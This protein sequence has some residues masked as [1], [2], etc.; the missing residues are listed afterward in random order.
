M[1]GRR[2]RRGEAPPACVT[3]AVPASDLWLAGRKGMGQWR[4][5]WVWS[6]RYI[7]FSLP[8]SSKIPTT[9]SSPGSDSGDSLPTLS[10]QKCLSLYLSVCLWL[11]PLP[12]HLVLSVCLCLLHACHHTAIYLLLINT[13][14]LY[15]TCMPPFLSF[16][17]VCL[18]ASLIYTTMPACMTC[19]FP[20][21]LFVS[22]CI[23][24]FPIWLGQFCACA[25]LPAIKIRHGKFWN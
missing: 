14:T 5:S 16:L 10:L 20:L 19:N 11:F 18:F 22:H 2:R 15:L 23:C 13:N 12:R 9:T 21:L 7:I 17:P 4:S 25:C 24:L 8:F 3:E 1:T 6:E